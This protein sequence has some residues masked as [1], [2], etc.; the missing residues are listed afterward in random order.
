MELKLTPEEVAKV[1][2]AKAVHEGNRIE[3]EEM[4]VAEFGYYYGWEGVEAIL[5][6]RISTS[7]MMKLLKGARKV[8]YSKL[9]DSSIATYTATGAVNSKN[10]KKTMKD[11]LRGF[12][13]EA[14]L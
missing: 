3:P 12:M 8:W 13:K 6:N 5:T 7:T 10:P 1:E 9:I 4:L 11:G 14:K 2:R